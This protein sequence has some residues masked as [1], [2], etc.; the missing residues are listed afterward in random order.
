MSGKFFILIKVVFEERIS[1]KYLVE[2]FSGYQIVVSQ[3]MIDIISIS[4]EYTY[5]NYSLFWI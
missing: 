4:F 3:W 2:E 1:Y 5:S